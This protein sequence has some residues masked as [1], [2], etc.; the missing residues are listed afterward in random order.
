MWIYLLCVIILILCHLT[1]PH[2]KNGRLLN[3]SMFIVGF[4]FCG[5]YMTG[6]DWRSYELDY[7]DCDLS[8]Y[9]YVEAGFVTLQLVLKTFGIGFWSFAVISKILTFIVIIKFCKKFTPGYFYLAFSCF[10]VFE[11]IAVFI[12]FPMQNAI[13]FIISL[14][15]IKYYETRCLKK[16]LIVN[17][18]AFFMHYAAI[19]MLPLYFIRLKKVKTKYIFYIFIFF[20]VV[21]TLFQS[22]F[23][24]LLMNNL[25]EVGWIF[26]KYYDF[27]LTNLE[28]T[29]R[30]GIS[31]GY[32]FHVVF[33]CFIIAQR[34]KIESL[35]YGNFLFMS[36]VLYP[37][38]YKLSLTISIL[39]RFE[40]FVSVPYFCS[41]AIALSNIS[42][43]KRKYV[44][45][46]VYIYMLLFTGR[47]VSSTW[48][49]VPYTHIVMELFDNYP[50][51]YRDNYNLK[52]SPYKNIE[53]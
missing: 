12:D 22:F 17:L 33:F 21:I 38:I 16:Y 23:L 25:G 44:V 36:G 28:E 10:L 11:G 48:K 6:S 35:P 20:N 3:I 52:N 53:K 34:D 51:S 8:S 13:S 41:I 32:L 1:D 42:F 5:G 19:I 7:Y 26:Q 30:F 40:Y 24:N 9:N 14:Y 29:A 47:T 50:Y 37:F 49:F 2:G 31:F 18:V 15:S 4:I 45:F 39:G 43:W 46:F 27:Y